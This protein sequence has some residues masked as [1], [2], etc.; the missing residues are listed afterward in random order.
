MDLKELE[1]FIKTCLE[2]EVCLGLDW[3]GIKIKSISPQCTRVSFIVQGA[4]HTLDFIYDRIGKS[5]ED[6]KITSIKFT[7]LQQI[8]KCELELVKDLKDKSEI[9]N[10]KRSEI[11]KDRIEVLKTLDNCVSALEDEIMILELLAD[12]FKEVGLPGKEDETKYIADI[13]DEYINK[14][15]NKLLPSIENIRNNVGSI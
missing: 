14:L 12:S 2:D 1:E 6:I 15:D 9:P 11:E 3:Y 4:D 10:I 13:L 5:S 7:Y 8:I